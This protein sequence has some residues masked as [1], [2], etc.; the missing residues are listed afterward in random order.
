MSMHCDHLE[1]LME[2]IADGTFEPAGEDREHLQTCAVCQ[3]RAAQARAI[4]EW[5]QVRA[6][7][8]PPASFTAGVMQRV[9]RENWRTE[10]V[11]DLGFNLAIAAGVLVILAGA[12]G[13]AWSLGYLTIT[14]DL[15]AL[16]EFGGG[17]LGQKVVSQ[18]QNIGL[19]AMLLTM[20]LVLWW[21]AETEPTM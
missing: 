1:P 12:A 15:A 17:Q 20:T 11:F 18:I 8:T 13:L 5:L 19:A 4:D 2:A 14:L 3:A 9:A 6:V 21:W 16:A 10:R 7:P